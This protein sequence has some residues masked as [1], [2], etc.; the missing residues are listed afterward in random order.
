MAIDAKCPFCEK[1][2]RLKDDFAGKKVTCANQDCRKLF[3]VTPSTNGAPKPVVKAAVKIDAE[4][5]AAQALAD[6]P[7][8][9]SHVPVDVRTI[10]MKCAICDF[11]W[12]VPWLTQGKNT[13]CPDCKHRQKVPEQKELKKAD[14][15]DSLGGRPSQAKVEE[16]EGVTDAKQARMV[17]GETLRET[18]VFKQEY[19][20]RPTSFYV[21]IAAIALFAITAMATLVI[22]RNRRSTETKELRIIDDIVK[23]IDADELKDL[24]LYRATLRLSAGEFEA[25]AGKDKKDRDRA[26]EFFNAAIA[27]LNAAPKTAEREM[28]YGELAVAVLMLGGEG[29][30]VIDQR[31]LTWL[32]QQ[33]G[34][35]RAK[36]RPSKAE[37]EGVQGQF[38]RV[39][40]GLQSSRADFELRT[41]VFRRA[42]RELLKVNQIE[43]LRS[44]LPAAFAELEQYEA[45]AQIGMECLRAGQMATA[46]EIGEKLQK[47]LAPG[48]LKPAPTPV[49][50]QALWLAL[51]PPI[52]GPS[53][54]SAPTSAGEISDGTRQAYTAFHMLK[55]NP[56]EAKAIAT[57]PGRADSRLRALA[58]AAEWSDK[59]GEFVDEAV[60][61]ASLEGKKKDSAIPPI[62]LVRLAQSAARAGVADQAD[63]FAKLISDDGLK[64]W[65]RAE[66]LRNKLAAD[67]GQQPTDE[68]AEIPADLADHKKF[69]LGHAWGRL[70]LARHTALK[71]GKL[72]LAK[73]YSSQWPRNTI[74]PFGLAGVMLG[75]QDAERK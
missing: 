46:R 23:A 10:E 74:A 4:T 2:Y 16:L 72:D 1:P 27:D 37:E 3:V 70:Q 38:R 54:A 25:R 39:V 22:M 14:W 21:K 69:R 55:N 61:I 63:E 45:E 50:A 57:R 36:V 62:T 24:P 47:A 20:P 64:A 34:N 12:D 8:A 13:L 66:I 29:S 71:N 44:N 6:D 52:K 56:T 53:L 68:A 60:K 31:K 75:V 18:G 58:L 42:A 32:P 43:V 35:S 19:E 33:N 30:D 51:D 26:V 5:L 40:Q 7:D 59:P 41:A 9:A 28:L 15:R 49:S 67:R 73:T 48:T 11:A 65:A 17:S